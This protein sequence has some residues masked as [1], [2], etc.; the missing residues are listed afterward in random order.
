VLELLQHGL[1]PRDPQRPQTLVQPLQ[2]LAKAL[3]LG[4]VSDPKAPFAAVADKVREAEEV[5][6]L[7]T[8]PPVLVTLLL[9]LI[10]KRS[11][12]ILVGSTSRSKAANRPLSSYRNLFASSSPSKH[13]MKSSPYRTR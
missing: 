5:K 13:P 8:A 1:A 10:P 11:T 12:P 9:S 3:A 7:G 2:L 4:L 6:G